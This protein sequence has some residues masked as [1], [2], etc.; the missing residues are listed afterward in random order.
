MQSIAETCVRFDAA[1]L[2]INL[3]SEIAV[4]MFTTLTPPILHVDEA[5]LG[6]QRIIGTLRRKWDEYNRF[7]KKHCTDTLHFNLLILVF[8]ISILVLLVHSIDVRLSVSF[9]TCYGH[10][11]PDCTE[12]HHRYHHSYPEP[13]VGLIHGFHAT[14]GETEAVNIIMYAWIMLP[15]SQAISRCF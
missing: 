14:A 7:L 15:C 13:R 4:P 3:V 12:H 6:I 8:C 9:P 10:C 2:S 1:H 11:R 5:Y